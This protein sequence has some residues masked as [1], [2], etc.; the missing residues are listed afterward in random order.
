M[1]AEPCLLSAEYTFVVGV[2]TKLTSSASM[3]VRLSRKRL[4]LCSTRLRPVGT[5]VTN[6]NGMLIV[7]Y[8]RGVD[9]AFVALRGLQEL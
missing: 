2:F 3:A 9:Q 8:Q 7:P 6:S 1:T 4:S 5:L